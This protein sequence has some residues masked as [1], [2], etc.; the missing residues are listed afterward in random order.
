MYDLRVG[1]ADA[2]DIAIECTGAVDRIRTETWNIGP[3]RGPLS[4]ALTGD[5]DVVLKPGARVKPIIAQI[6]ALLR[7][8]EE[9]GLVGFFPIDEWQLRRINRP[10]HSKFHVLDIDS[11][12]CFRLDGTGK[13]HLG[14]TGIGGIVDTSGAEVPGWI[15]AFLRAPE[16]ADVLFKLRNSGARECHAFVPV[17]FASVPWAVESYLGRPIEVLPTSPPDLPDPV[18]SVW[19]TYGVNGIRWDGVAWRLFDASPED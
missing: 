19:I 3:A 8:C 11:I 4:L 12:H 1:S 15:S 6:E 9:Q 2:P 13:V 5:W 10:L 16:Q 18:S 14:M 7:E 17:A